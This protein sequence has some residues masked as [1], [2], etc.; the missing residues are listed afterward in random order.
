MFLVTHQLCGGGVHLIFFEVSF[1]KH[2]NGHVANHSSRLSSIKFAGEICGFI[3][4]I[5]K[6]LHG[7]VARKSTVIVCVKYS[8]L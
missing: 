6:K 8:S 2:P 7:M 5:C 3:D 1:E 4:Y